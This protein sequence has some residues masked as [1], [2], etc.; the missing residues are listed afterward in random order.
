MT[1]ATSAVTPLERLGRVCALSAITTLVIAVAGALPPLQAII[2]SKLMTRM[3]HFL[4]VGFAGF[5]LFA[6]YF[7]A[8]AHCARLEG[9]DER[10]RWRARLSRLSILGGLW[11]WLSRHRTAGE[12]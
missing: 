5:T 12:A 11:Y 8:L 2:A 3:G 7:S 4:V 9:T 10:L 6:A 1:R